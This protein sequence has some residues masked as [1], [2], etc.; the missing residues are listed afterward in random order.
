MGSYSI[1][2]DSEQRDIR[3]HTDAISKGS[4][5]LDHPANLPSTI[6]NIEPAQLDTLIM[7]G[8]AALVALV[9]EDQQMND[10]IKVLPHTTCQ[11]SYCSKPLQPTTPE[12]DADMLIRKE[13]E[14]AP[15]PEPDVMSEVEEDNI[16]A[17]TDPNPHT[18]NLQ[19]DPNPYT[20]KLLDL[21]QEPQDPDLEEVL[22]QEIRQPTI[23]ERILEVRHIMEEDR[24]LREQEISG[25]LQIM[26]QGQNEM[27][28]NIKIILGALNENKESFQA[29]TNVMKEAFTFLN[30]QMANQLKL[31]SKCIGEQMAELA[32]EIRAAITPPPRPPPPPPPQP[33]VV[34][35]MSESFFTSPTGEIR[36]GGGG[37]FGKSERGGGSSKKNG[38]VTPADNGGE[39]RVEPV[40]EPVVGI[41]EKPSRDSYVEGNLPICNLG[42]SGTPL[43][44]SPHG[45]TSTPST[46]VVQSDTSSKTDS[47]HIRDPDSHMSNSVAACYQGM[48]ASQHVTGST[49]RKLLT[50]EEIK[51]EIRHYEAETEVMVRRADANPL[52]KRKKE[53]NELGVVARVVKAVANDPSM[54]L[55][56]KGQRNR[57][58]TP[59]QVGK[60]TR[61]FQESSRRKTP[62][63][64]EEEDTCARQTTPVKT[65]KTPEEEGTCINAFLGQDIV[66]A[67]VTA[68]MEKKERGVNGTPKQTTLT[69]TP[70]QPGRRQATPK[71]E[72]REREKDTE[73]VATGSNA[74]KLSDHSR[75]QGTNANV[76]PVSSKAS[77]PETPG[78]GANATP[79]AA[80]SG[81]G[82]NATP[83][84]PSRVTTPPT[85]PAQETTMLAHGKP[86]RIQRTRLGGKGYWEQGPKNTADIE[87]AS[88]PT[89]VQVLMTG[90]PTIPARGEGW[91]RSFLAGFNAK[92]ERLTPETPICATHVSFAFSY[93][94][95][96][97]VTIHHPANTK[98]EE[99]IRAVAR[100][101]REMYNNYIQHPNESLVSILQETTELVAPGLQGT[102]GEKAWDR[103]ESICRDLNL[104]RA[105]RPPKW[106]VK[107]KGDGY[108]GKK[109]S[110]RLSVTTASLRAIKSPLPIPYNKGKI[111]LYQRVD[112]KAFYVDELK[113]MVVEPRPSHSPEP[114]QP[115]G[116]HLLEQEEC[117]SMGGTQRDTS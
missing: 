79:K 71:Q 93:P 48:S 86:G 3:K 28:E 112:D 62:E 14:T 100:V 72:V 77:H 61:K 117:P 107:G 15:S 9:P 67:E 31:L 101:R 87:N 13:R 21:K 76:A 12:E 6:Q 99:I 81:T 82:T 10:T 111:Y 17:H 8:E 7:S 95:E 56:R 19:P 68:A 38:G 80:R 18:G 35:P 11:V 98:H 43:K 116:G 23:E 45:D 63:E 2:G 102:R 60:F 25:V 64:E 78:T 103:A 34:Q 50:Q 36:R 49:P 110:L 27:R 66:E 85:E 26:D 58:R 42:A 73:R 20:P 113:Y 46:E 40:V 53:A 83:I 16:D 59:V 89:S 55:N 109:C 22:N 65:Y 88:R 54:R 108:E 75:Q 91:K 32:Q 52:L 41:S 90:C 114:G 39:P 1:W 92:R 106:L 96:R 69:P 33:S 51:A 115:Y 97:V 29:Q 105:A 74:T 4:L 84:G 47:E 37:D 70:R 44:H 24:E 104:T 57:Q 94:S 5:L 30:R